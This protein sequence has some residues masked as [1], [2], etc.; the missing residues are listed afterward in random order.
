MA[1]G[2]LGTNGEERRLST[3]VATRIEQGARKRQED[4]VSAV[5]NE[6]GSWVIAVA[7]GVGGVRRGDEAAPAALAALPQRISGDDEMTAAFAA[8]NRAVRAL[9]PPNS[10]YA[11]DEDMPGYWAVEPVTTLA[12]AAWTPEQGMTAAWVGDSIMWSLR[13]FLGFGLLG[14][15]GSGYVVRMP[16][17]SKLV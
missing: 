8:A 13:V 7:D 14:S 16:R 3:E 11:L 1:V 5:A 10:M 12:V 9:A 17:A 2:E 15:A 6:D 4:A